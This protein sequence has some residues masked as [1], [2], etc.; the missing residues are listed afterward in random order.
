M[1]DLSDALSEI[2]V[3]R[4]TNVLISGPPLAGKADIA[5][6][7]LANG[8]RQ[9]DGT[10]VVTTKDDARTVLG[11]IRDRTGDA[12]DPLIGI[13]DAVTRQQGTTPIEDDPHVSYVSSPNDM[14]SIGIQLSERLEEFHEQHQ[15]DR[16]RVLLHSVSTL[17]MYSDLETVFRFLHVFTGRITSTGALGLYTIDSTAQDDQTMN[18]LTQLFDGVI[19]IEEDED[20]ERRIH[21][22]GLTV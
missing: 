14:T 22:A 5:Y 7:V 6:D 18:T 9:G 8:I 17:L 15:R 1:Y 16:N 11:A 12:D 21:T 2:T 19:E 10:I 3:D 13:V 4:G 20:S